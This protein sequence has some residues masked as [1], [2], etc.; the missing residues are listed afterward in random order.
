[1]YARACNALPL[2]ALLL[3]ASCARATPAKAPVQ[4][5]SK[6]PAAQDDGLAI[7]GAY[8][9]ELH[10]GSEEFGGACSI[11]QAAE[12]MQLRMELGSHRLQGDLTATAYG[13]RL[14]GRFD[15]ETLEVD[16]MRQGGK[17]FAAVLQLADQSLGK[18]NMAPSA[19]PSGPAPTDS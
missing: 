16:F 15:E 2:A 3:L 13:F 17:S 19:K 6:A 12:G 4:R 18:I 8:T 14:H 9:C 5:P 11:V 7:E 10:L 1:M